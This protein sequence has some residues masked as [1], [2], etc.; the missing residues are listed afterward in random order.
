MARRI[1]IETGHA[2]IELLLGCYY[3]DKKQIVLWR[4]GIELCAVGLVDAN[5]KGLSISHLSFCVLI[6]ELGHW[7]NAE[8]ISPRGINW[9]S[10]PLTLSATRR[11]EVSGPIDPYDLD[12]SSSPTLMGDARSLSSRAY[13]ESW[14]QLFVWLYGQEQN[15]GVLKV[16][17]VLET[18]QS[19]PYQAWRH[20]VNVHP[21]PGPGPYGLS[22]LR[23][24][25]HRILD[26]LQWSRSLRDPATGAA[27]PATFNDA[28]FTDTNMLAWLDG[29][30]A[31]STA[32]YGES[33]PRASE[34]LLAANSIDGRYHDNGDGTVTDVETGLQWM[35]AALGQQ[36]D[37][38][39]ITGAPRKYDWSEA[40]IAVKRFNQRGGYSGCMDWRIP[41]IEELKTLIYCS[42]GQPKTWNDTGHCCKGEH[43]MPTLS[44]AVFGNKT[45]GWCWSMSADPDDAENQWMVD[46]TSGYMGKYAQSLTA[47]VRLV[48][49]TQKTSA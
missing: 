14:A 11:Q 39:G 22:D 48:R 18:V 37:F 36:W 20:L 15:P 4:K 46:F 7:F 21:N 5:G 25:Q 6:H 13:H 38:E 16:F 1:R 3:W 35:R 47:H 40:I 30:P 8:A 43:D 19:A 31:K 33:P 12:Q 27:K 44:N 26:S 49:N 24:S 32:L 9:D 41:T 17:E 45:G 23:W 2:D 29:V 34:P 28:H 10:A 42:T